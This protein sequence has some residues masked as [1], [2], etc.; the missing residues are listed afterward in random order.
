MGEGSQSLWGNLG[1][2]ILA[3][4]LVLLLSE[5]G[6]RL[7]A[8]QVPWASVG[9]QFVA[10]PKVGYLLR[11]G[12]RGS[13]RT[14]EFTVRY[15]HNLQGLR[16]REQTPARP[17]TGRP[18][19]GSADL[20]VLGLGDSFAYGEGAPFSR[21]YFAAL[22]RMLPRWRGRKVRITKAGVPGYCSAHQLAWLREF[23]PGH[24]PQVVLL[25]VPINDVL[26]NLRGLAAFQVIGGRLYSKFKK[27]KK[28][29]IG[30]IPR[31]VT[32]RKLIKRYCHLCMLVQRRVRLLVGGRDRRLHPIL[33]KLYARKPGPAIRRAWDLTRTYLGGIRDLCSR[34]RVK[35]FVVVLP[36][37]ERF[38]GS[39]GPQVDVKGT[40]DR[41]VGLLEELGVDTLDP[42]AGLARRPGGGGAL[43]WPRDGHMK[44]EG[45]ERLAR[46]T[47]RWLASR[48][49][50]PT[51]APATRRRATV[52][53]PG[54][55]LKPRPSRAPARA[56]PSPDR[57]PPRRSRPLRPP[58]S[59]R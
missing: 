18:D 34:R 6:V 42:T 3:L 9:R 59:G 1:L 22:E 58:A 28:L 11:P 8:P 49:L 25:L 10:H 29:G 53:P 7:A 23:G 21:T 20:R 39:F 35:L 52:E 45:Y 44:P 55:R 40:I 27:F 15:R 36:P 4:T 16:D 33:R 2:A 47:A 30:G 13:Y 38:G 14:P 19:R 46:I 24:R 5:C 48:S 37:R 32:L 43:Y 56:A 26:D 41:L 31:P 17:A 51:V 12:A 54:P 57:R 50:R